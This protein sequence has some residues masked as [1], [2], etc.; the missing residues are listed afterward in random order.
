LLF[1]QDEKYRF[2]AACCFVFAFHAPVLAKQ[3]KITSDGWVNEVIYDR[4]ISFKGVDILSSG[5]NPFISLGKQ[6]SVDVV[7]VLL[8]AIPALVPARFC[9]LLD[10]HAACAEP[11]CA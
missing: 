11:G 8:I 9:R 2:S 1:F 5:A 3:S 10:P 6:K 7:H 4:D